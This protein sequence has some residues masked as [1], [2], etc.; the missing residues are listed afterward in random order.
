MIR[1]AIPH[2]IAEILSSLLS[3]WIRLEDSGDAFRSSEVTSKIIAVTANHK[4]ISENV[5]GKFMLL[6]PVK[7]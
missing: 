5:K 3:I 6:A 4:L 2:P 1:K 7:F